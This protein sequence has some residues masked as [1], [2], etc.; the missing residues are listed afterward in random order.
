[1]V[2]K[3]LSAVN[4]IGDKLQQRLEYERLESLQLECLCQ[5]LVQNPSIEKQEQLIIKL[6]K[7]FL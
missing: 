5:V 1:M 4:D 6:G 2:Q 7:K 3:T